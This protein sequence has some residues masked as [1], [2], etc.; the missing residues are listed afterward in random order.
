GDPDAVRLLA[1]RLTS[2]PDTLSWHRPAVADALRDCGP[3]G[4][5]ALKKLLDDP[6]AEVR[7]AVVVPL[8]YEADRDPAVVPALSAR[9]KDPNRDVRDAALRAL[10]AA[11]PA[12]KGAAREVAGRLKDPVASTRTQ[13]AITLAWLGGGDDRAALVAALRHCLTA[14]ETAG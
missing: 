3:D 14:P 13:A 4:V 12:A 2:T 9:L 1:E 10:R 8:G 7:A 11:G 5:A 6:R